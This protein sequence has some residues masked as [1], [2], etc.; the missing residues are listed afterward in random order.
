MT[1]L[2]I[3]LYHHHRL[4]A[5]NPQLA[6]RRN[7][8]NSQAK[9][10]LK[11]LENMVAPQKPQTA[12]E[13]IHK[14]V[15]K[16]HLPWASKVELLHQKYKGNH[17]KNWPNEVLMLLATLFPADEPKAKLDGKQSYNLFKSLTAMLLHLEEEAQLQ[18]A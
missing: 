17:L 7:R 3:D 15:E 6:K 2:L 9:S 16:K 1:T 18:S 13:T 8:I 4:P 5:G 11:L 14:I 12:L 10:K